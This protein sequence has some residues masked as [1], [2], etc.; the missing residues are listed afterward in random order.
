M[1]RFYPK[2]PRYNSEVSREQERRRR[3]PKLFSREVTADLNKHLQPVP[4]AA[5]AVDGQALNHV[6]EALA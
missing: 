2:L 6:E 4:V 3:V 1:S 5:R